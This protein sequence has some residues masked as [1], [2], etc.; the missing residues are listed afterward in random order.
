M[1]GTNKASS[2]ANDKTEAHRKA[3]I[4]LL[5]YDA[6]RSR[7][8]SPTRKEPQTRYP[9]LLTIFLRNSLAKD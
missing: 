5:G 8:T 7:P 9:K 2:P 3:N 4:L 6:R 1:R